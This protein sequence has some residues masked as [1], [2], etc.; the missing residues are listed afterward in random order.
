MRQ[1]DVAFCTFRR[2]TEDATNLTEVADALRT[3]TA[4]TFVSRT[5]AIRTALRLAAGTARRGEMGAALSRH[6]ADLSAG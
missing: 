6:N 2:T 3:A 4:R 5:E 1:P